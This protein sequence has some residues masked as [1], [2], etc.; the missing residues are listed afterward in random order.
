M[1]YNVFLR[2]GI[3]HVR[4]FPCKRIIFIRQ[5]QVNISSVAK[6]SYLYQKKQVSFFSFKHL[7]SSEH[8]TATLVIAPMGAQGPV[9]QLRKVGGARSGPGA[10]SAWRPGSVRSRDHSHHIF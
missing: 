1:I 6:N 10:A 2:H 5:T 9:N 4:L 7:A 8:R 3:T